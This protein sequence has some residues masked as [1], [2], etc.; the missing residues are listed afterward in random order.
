M[1]ISFKKH[2]IYDGGTKIV[3]V[4]ENYHPDIKK[5][6]AIK[7]YDASTKK[8][9][10]INDKPSYV[11]YSILSSTKLREYYYDSDYV[12]TRLSGPAVI[13]RKPWSNTKVEKEYW[14]DREPY[15]NVASYYF[16]VLL[17]NINS[18]FALNK[19]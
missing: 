13:N 3:K 4:I 2:F 19:K 18:Y 15:S 17:Y 9:M 14:I 8:W 11:E 1:E 16:S 10:S 6:V 7:T 12:L 5:I